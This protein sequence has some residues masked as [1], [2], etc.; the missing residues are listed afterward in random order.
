MSRLS[1][2]TELRASNGPLASPSPFPPPQGGGN[3]REGAG[4]CIAYAEV[5]S[6]RQVWSWYRCSGAPSRISG[7]FGLV[8]ARSCTTEAEPADQLPSAVAARCV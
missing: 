8:R 5:S 3:K 1:A 4:S 2:V 6:R 7:Q